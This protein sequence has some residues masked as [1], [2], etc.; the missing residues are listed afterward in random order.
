MNRNVWLFLVCWLGLQMQLPAAPGPSK[1]TIALLQKDAARFP[2]I[3]LGRDRLGES[4]LTVIEPPEKAIHADGFYYHAFRFKAPEWMDGPVNW[5]LVLV[6]NVPFQSGQF[7]W[8]V[9]PA[10]GET[11]YQNLIFYERKTTGAPRVAG[12]F[13]KAKRYIEQ[14]LPKGFI[15][16]GK[17][18]IV[19]HRFHRPEVMRIAV[20]LTIDSKRGKNELGVL[21]TSY[22][23]SN[24]PDAK[25]VAAKMFRNRKKASDEAVL[26]DL[27]G[28]F[29]VRAP[30][31]S[32]FIPMFTAAWIEA[33]T[34]GGR[35][36]PEWAAAVNELTFRKSLE[37]GYL[38]QAADIASNLAGSLGNIR[39]YGRRTEILDLMRKAFAGNGLDPDPR[40]YPDRGPAIAG[41]PE[42]RKRDIPPTVPWGN[43]ERDTN[44]V[45]TRPA[46]FS[47]TTANLL[48]SMAN[49][50]VDSGHW[51]E[52]LEW[53][54][55]IGDWAETE[56]ARKMDIEKAN[57]WYKSQEATASTLARLDLL[58]A[59]AG[60]FRE[61]EDSKLPDAYQGRTKTVARIRAL[62][63][64]MELGGFEPGFVDRS[65]ELA[66][67]LAKNR[68]ST[69]A[70]EMSARCVHATA[71]LLAGREDEGLG[72]LDQLIGNGSERARFAKIRWLLEKGRTHELEDL[73]VE[74]LEFLRA[75][76]LK[77]SEAEIYSLYAD[78]LESEGR[79]SEALQIRKQ[80]LGLCRSF[81]LFVGLPVEAAGVSRLLAR[82]GDAAGS[83]AAAKEAEEALAANVPERVRN[84]VR[85]TLARL[86]SAR[87]SETRTEKNG[88]V[89]LQ[90]RSVVVIPIEGITSETSLGLANPTDRSEGGRLVVTGLPVSTSVDEE[91][92]EVVVNVDN[93]SAS[94]ELTLEPGE[95]WLIRIRL[96][97]GLKPGS[98]LTVAWK[99][100]PDGEE[101]TSSTILCEAADEGVAAAVIEA[102]EFRLNPFYGVP[103]RHHFISAGTETRSPPVRFTASQAARIE[104]YGGDDMLWCVDA[105]GNGSLADAGDERHVDFGDSEPH[106]RL[107]LENGRSE[108]RVQVYPVGGLPAEGMT[109]KLEILAG[110]EWIPHAEDRIVR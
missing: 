11:K 35:D 74:S 81:H 39:K 66:D 67:Q 57:V 61:I 19:W 43:L 1:E 83:A 55:W 29:D 104:V 32:A 49:E 109:L 15:L 68:F 41:F 28:E 24:V 25:A 82:M 13:P 16:P 97:A 102:G 47:R 99:P 62:G 84:E 36:A 48:Q 18:Y 23:V 2:L 26:A 103:I 76:S 95:Y 86:P 14:P 22:R 7:S 3:P 8:F 108:V 52:A 73:I 38:V 5:A 90:P 78:F 30:H 27:A 80:A 72:L 69:R 59:A 10:E 40:T 50:R 71:L 4:I 45:V 106:I 77:I 33:Q 64:A 17:E 100:S 94:Q 20:A 65:R 56:C 53:S 12:R 88:K 51:I 96:D 6:D 101:S 107:P 98:K 79:L 93:G 21:P 46:R 70:N 31:P 105:Q 60:R 54:A 75:N 37:H 87:A 34:G 44:G 110:E 85:K 42:I 63:I 9:I 89:D 92:G 91:R 58:E